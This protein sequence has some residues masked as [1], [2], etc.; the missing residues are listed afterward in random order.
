M[1]KKLYVHGGGFHAD[2]VFC[3]A[4]LRIINEDLITERVIAADRDLTDIEHGILM[5]DIGGGPFDHHQKDVPLR[6][7]GI[8]HCAVTQ[9]WK[10][11]GSECIRAVTHD[12]SDEIVSAVSDRIYNGILR[13]IAVLDNGTEGVLP[14]GVIN[15]CDLADRFNPD[16]DSD[17]NPEAAFADAALFAQG[18][19]VRE[20][21]HAVSDLKAENLVREAVQEM[22]DGIIVLDQYLPW[23]HIVVQ[24]PDAKIVIYPS[25]RKEI[26]L[27]LVPVEEGSFTTRLDVPDAWKGK[28]NA[29]ADACMHGMVFCHA[30]GF[31]M[32]FNDLENAI[33]AAHSLV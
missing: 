7:D 25:A 18:V 30:T 12:V 22:E 24:D 16:W 3:D 28:R 20:I 11:F 13:E 17:E 19:L 23:E 15:I 31:L 10:R 8:R 9:L 21:R 14:G 26:N 27:R 32:A 5:A 4:V 1:I 29:E 2:D 33:S 6:E